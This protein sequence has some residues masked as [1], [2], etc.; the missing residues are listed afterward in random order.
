MREQRIKNREDSVKA[1]RESWK[2]QDDALD[3]AAYSLQARKRELQTEQQAIAKIRAFANQ[4]GVTL[5]TAEKHLRARG[6]ISKGKMY[7][8]KGGPYH[9]DKIK[10][11]L[12]K[13]DNITKVS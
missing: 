7:Y 11:G 8:G 9:T 1:L 13:A 12:D 3:A 2:R 10:S 4:T 6:E 5:E